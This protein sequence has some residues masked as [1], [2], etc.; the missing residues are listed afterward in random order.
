M[1][2]ISGR[3]AGKCAHALAASIAVYFVSLELIAL[4]GLI[5]KWAGMARADAVMLSVMLGF[6]YLWA[7]LIHVFS[8]PRVIDAWLAIALTGLAATLGRFALG[9]T[10]A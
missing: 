1:S 10:L 6:C 2:V 9:A 4:T 8:R 7:L 3:M 5:G